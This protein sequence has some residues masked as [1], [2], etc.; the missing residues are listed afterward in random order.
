MAVGVTAKL[1][2]GL[3]RR[4]VAITLLSTIVLL[5]STLLLRGDAVVWPQFSATISVPIVLAA[6]V[7]VLAVLAIRLVDALSV[8][9]ILGAVG[10]GVSLLYLWFSA[11]DLAITQVMIET[12][13]TILLVLILF[14]L[15][16]MRRLSSPSQRMA[17]MVLAIFGGG[18]VSLV[19]W[20]VMAAPSPVSISEWLIARSMPEGH[21]RNI[22]NVILVDFRALDTLG[23][24]VVLALAAMGGYALL[25]SPPNTGERES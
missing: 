14:R 18:I 12:L 25:K 8:A 17:D 21:G 23:E 24:I 2:S 15:P 9:L 1:Q 11:P 20:Q 10:F 16:R 5:L 7:L 13:T 4:Y 22:V 6:G 3:L 19:L